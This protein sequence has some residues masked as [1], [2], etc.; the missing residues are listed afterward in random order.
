[1]PSAEDVPVYLLRVELAG[2]GPFEIEVYPREGRDFLL[3]RDLLAQFLFAL[4]GP[5]GEF[6]LRRTC[7]FDR[8]LRRLLRCP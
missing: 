6:R 4:D 5:V 8:Y 1:V 7:A 2:R 3:G